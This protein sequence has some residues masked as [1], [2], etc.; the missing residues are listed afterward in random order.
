MGI[1]REVPADLTVSARIDEPAISDDGRTTST[2][3]SVGRAQN[4]EFWQRFIACSRFDHPDQTPPRH[5]GNNYVRLDLPGPVTGMVAYR[6]ADGQAGFVM[7][8][9]GPEGRDF[10]QA[11]LE[12]QASLESEVGQPIRFDIGDTT[13]E[14]DRVVGAMLVDY[15]PNE[16]AD[17]AAEQLSWLLKTG[18]ALVNALRPRLGTTSA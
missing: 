12:D 18:N 1:G 15:R 7:K 10:M 8:F 9:T 14:S 17:L 13:A 11:L 16:G 5:G 3:G 4:K 2:P 6:T